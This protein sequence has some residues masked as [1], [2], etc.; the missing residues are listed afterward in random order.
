MVEFEASV[1]V[2]L[3]VVTA[4]VN[5][6]RQNYDEDRSESKK[7]ENP[8]RAFRRKNLMDVIL[9]FNDRRQNHHGY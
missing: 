4:P 6:Y 3:K 5:P 2:I 1:R 7:I 9:H 8:S